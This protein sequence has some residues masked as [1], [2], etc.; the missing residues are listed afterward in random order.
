MSAW[1]R[2]WAEA[3][4][5]FDLLGQGSVWTSCEVQERSPG[6]PRSTTRTCLNPS[7]SASSEAWAPVHMN[8]IPGLRL[9]P[10]C[11]PLPQ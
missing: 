2:P 9:P 10:D 6:A 11:R 8:P 5:W 1:L 3:P 7:G 4:A